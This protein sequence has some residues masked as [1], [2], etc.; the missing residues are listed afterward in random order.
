MPGILWHN[1]ED[2]EIAKKLAIL[3]M[4]KDKIIIDN[5]NFHLFT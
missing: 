2:Q 4:I 5:T 1:L 3:D